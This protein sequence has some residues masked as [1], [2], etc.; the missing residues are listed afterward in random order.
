MKESFADIVNSESQR[1]YRLC[2][3]LTGNSQ[4]AEDLCQDALARALKSF[5]QFE[6]RSQISTWLYRI[7][8]NAWKNKMRTKRTVTIFG[9]FRSEE[10]SESGDAS[11]PIEPVGH[12]APLESGIE[13]SESERLLQSALD[14]L[15]PEHREIVVL[16]DIEDK[17]YDELADLLGVPIGTV[18]SRLARARE[19]L[20]LKLAPILKSKGEIS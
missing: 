5:H 15:D 11:M 8:L 2:F 1:L 13:R 18:K 19:A 16:R 6:G 4:E 9:F 17:S 7:A 12:D 3:R 20:R 10:K 14:G